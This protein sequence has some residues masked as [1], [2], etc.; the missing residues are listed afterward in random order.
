MNLGG[1]GGGAA[2]ASSMDIAD[3]SLSFVDIISAAD[4]V[5]TA[6]SHPRM[7]ESD[8]DEIVQRTILRTQLL[9]TV[10]QLQQHLHDTAAADDDHDD[11]D[12]H[13]GFVRSLL[14]PARFVVEIDDNVATAALEVQRAR[15]ISTEG[16]ISA[17]WNALS[18]PYDVSI[19]EP[20]LLIPRS[21]GHV[22]VNF[23]SRTT[24]ATQ[25][26]QQ[27]QQQ[28]QYAYEEET[29]A[30]LHHEH[31]SSSSQELG[32]GKVAVAYCT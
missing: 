13:D 5:M 16:I 17:D 31:H 10:A 30:L 26:Q 18:P 8:D 23:N 3:H 15:L 4:S 28:H 32:M 29:Q 20:L 2:A 12:D 9:R 22:D 25:Q 11:H 19:E 24:S 1:G 27:Q 6:D 7:V 14:D 21:S